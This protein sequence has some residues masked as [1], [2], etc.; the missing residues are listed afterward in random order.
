MKKS[1]LG[2]GVVAIMSIK[3]TATLLAASLLPSWPLRIAAFH[4]IAIIIVIAY[5]RHRKRNKPDR[6]T[7]TD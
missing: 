7:T 2:L 1:H 4:V 6:T 5:I 3:G